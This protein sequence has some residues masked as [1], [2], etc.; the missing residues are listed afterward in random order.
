MFLVLGQRPTDTSTRS[1]C[2]GAEF[3]GP[4]EGYHDFVFACFGNTT[5]FGVQEDSFFKQLVEF[6][7]R[8]V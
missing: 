3:S 6:F 5:N 4:F 8:V 7:E 1:N 2:F